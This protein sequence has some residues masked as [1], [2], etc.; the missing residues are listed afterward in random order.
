MQGIPKCAVNFDR[1]F[2]RL[3]VE[4]TPVDK[5]ILQQNP[6]AFPQFSYCSPY[7]QVEADEQVTRLWQ[8][9]QVQCWD[10]ITIVLSEFLNNL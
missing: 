2:T 8:L 7:Y 10:I 9:L 1:V 4:D 6:N 5:H 3:K